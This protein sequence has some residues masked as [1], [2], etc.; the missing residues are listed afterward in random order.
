MGASRA[1]QLRHYPGTASDEI[2]GNMDESGVSNLAKKT[3]TAET[4]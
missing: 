1:G 2:W 4:G 3:K